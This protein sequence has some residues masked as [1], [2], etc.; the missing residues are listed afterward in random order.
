MPPSRYATYNLL[1]RA[2]AI[3]IKQGLNFFVEILARHLRRYNVSGFLYRQSP[4][5]LPMLPLI[6]SASPSPPPPSQMAMRSSSPRCKSRTDVRMT[7][8][9]THPPRESIPPP[10]G[11]TAVPNNIENASR[12]VFFLCL[13]SILD[14]PGIVLVL[15]GQKKLSMTRRHANRAIP[16]FASQKHLSFL[17][18]SSIAF[19]PQ[20]NSY[21]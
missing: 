16:V 5:S 7:F 12:V 18:H 6:G 1:R 13:A 19:V 20:H 9:Q 2:P 10:A 11:Q 17:P 4:H 21:P 14:F 3:H 8:A 15:S